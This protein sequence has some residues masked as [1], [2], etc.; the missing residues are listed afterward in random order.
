MGPA[1]NTGAFIFGLSYDYAGVVETSC[2]Q[3]CQILT[4]LIWKVCCVW[5]N[6]TV[7]KLKNNSSRLFIGIS[8]V[9]LTACDAATMDT[10]AVVEVPVTEGGLLVAPTVPEAVTAPTLAEALQYDKLVVSDFD[11]ILG[12]GGTVNTGIPGTSFEK[13]PTS[14]NAFFRG[15]GQVDVFTRAVTATPTGTVTDDDSIVGMTGTAKVTVNFKD[16]T[17]TGRLDEMFGVSATTFETG[18]VDGVL[19]IAGTLPRDVAQ[20][21]ALDGRVAGTVTVLGTSYVLDMNADGLLRG[22]NPSSDVKVRAIGLSGEGTVAG[23][24]AIAAITI[25]GDRFN[26]D[27]TG[28]YVNR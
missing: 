15:P 17:F 16:S 8:C 19:S 18:L 12:D 4:I 14:N 23:S 1:G 10:A 2:N 7:N 28:A 25:V 13:V 3:W 21:N 11:R 6:W 26:G 5:G 27:G 24:S 20:P 22:T 9:A